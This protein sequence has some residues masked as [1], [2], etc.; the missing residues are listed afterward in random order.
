MLQV[1]TIYAREESIQRLA[2]SRQLRA[3]PMEVDVV[4]SAAEN[5]WK[6]KIETALTALTDAVTQLSARRDR[7]PRNREGG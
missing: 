5:P 2:R 3:E 1:A 7:R 4:K 6:V